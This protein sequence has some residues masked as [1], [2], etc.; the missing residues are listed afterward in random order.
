MKK[1]IF[2]FVLFLVPVQ[3]FSQEYQEKY[4][5]EYFKFNLSGTQQGEKQEKEYRGKYF[6]FTLLGGWEISP[7][8]AED[9]VVFTNTPPSGFQATLIAL[10]SDTEKDLGDLTEEL[11]NQIRSRYPDTKFFLE[12]WVSQAGAEWQ[13]L[14]YAYTDGDYTLQ[15]IQLL[16]VV[17]DKA[18][19]FT[20]VTQQQ[21]FKGYLGDFRKMFQSWRLRG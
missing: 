10:V 16:T 15:F 8:E 2:L 20:G 12:R 18:Y 19:S 21:D 11:K 5:S 4:R 13:E 1:L 3:A 7:Q 14:I 17:K 6:R 9:L